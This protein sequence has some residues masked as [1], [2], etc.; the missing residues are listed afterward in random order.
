MGFSRRYLA[1]L[2]SG[3]A[4]RSTR[5]AQRT[6]RSASRFQV[7]PTRSSASG[8]RRSGGGLT[9]LPV[10]NCKAFRSE[11]G[12]P[13][14]GR[15]R[16]PPGR[17]DPGRTFCSAPGRS[18]Q[19]ASPPALAEVRDFLGWDA[20]TSDTTPTTRSCR[21]VARDRAEALEWRAS[22]QKAT[23]H[24]RLGSNSDGLVPLVTVPLIP[25]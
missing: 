7:S 12:R 20:P 15:A 13:G 19:C 21:S 23:P 3:A 5:S 9:N 6:D 10:I 11:G 2:R 16:R 18:I 17:R 8:C 25:P 4:R 1:D 14:P 24:V 22:Q